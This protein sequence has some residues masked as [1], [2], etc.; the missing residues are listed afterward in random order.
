MDQF[1]DA[2]EKI[3]KLLKTRL[4]ELLVSLIM[5]GISAA[6]LFMGKI[7]EETWAILTGTVLAAWTGSQVY[8]QGRASKGIASTAQAAL[9]AV[10]GQQAAPAEP[11]APTPPDATTSTLPGG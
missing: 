5:I 4:D 9:Q 2:A 11:P 10:M 6:A 8:R 3:D 7:G 1:S